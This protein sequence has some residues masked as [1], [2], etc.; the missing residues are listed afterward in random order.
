MLM[1]AQER[2]AASPA[3]KMLSPREAER[4]RLGRMWVRSH[5]YEIEEGTLEEQ[6]ELRKQKAAWI[7]AELAKFDQK[8]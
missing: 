4:G 3:A 1:K 5:W 7:E 2:S 8:T 6:A